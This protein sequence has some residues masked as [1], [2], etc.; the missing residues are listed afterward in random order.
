MPKRILQQFLI[1]EGIADGLFE[2]GS[3]IG[4]FFLAGNGCGHWESSF[5]LVISFAVGT[6]GGDFLADLFDQPHLTAVHSLP[7]GGS[8]AFFLST[9]MCLD[10]HAVNAQKGR[11]ARIRC[12]RAAFGRRS[13][14]V[15]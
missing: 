15:L 5:L 10:D 9:A 14:F 4:E 2:A 8:D 12:D 11:A 7:Y 13:C 3:G 1:T 6:Q